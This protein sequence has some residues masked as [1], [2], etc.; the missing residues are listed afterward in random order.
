MF[1]EA[2]LEVAEFSFEIDT[3]AEDATGVGE[4]LGNVPEHAIGDI[5]V[6]PEERHESEDD[7]RNYHCNGTGV[8]NQVLNFHWRVIMLCMMN[9]GGASAY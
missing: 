4:C 3:H 1:F 7:A 9:I 6:V 8:L 2:R 5:A